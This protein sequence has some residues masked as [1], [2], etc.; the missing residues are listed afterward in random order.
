MGTW[1]I[2]YFIFIVV[3]MVFVKFVVDTIPMSTWTRVYYNNLLSVPMGLAS[4]VGLGDFEFLKTEWSLAALI[5]LL[6]SCVV[7][8]TISY[9]GFNLRKLISAT[10]FTVVGVV[11]KIITVLINGLIGKNHSNLYGHGGLGVCICA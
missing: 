8:I 11:C 5:V 1:L 2:V 7:G 10:S 6:S 9:A 3:E 4:L